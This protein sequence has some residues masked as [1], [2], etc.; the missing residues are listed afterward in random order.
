MRGVSVHG[1]Q[2]RYGDGC[3]SQTFN[4]KEWEEYDSEDE[5]RTCFYSARLFSFFMML[6]LRLNATAQLGGSS[7]REGLAGISEQM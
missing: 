3:R 1:R 7:K 6:L 2:L 4:L 5:L